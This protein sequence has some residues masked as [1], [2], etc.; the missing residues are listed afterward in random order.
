MS[1]ATQQIGQDFVARLWESFSSFGGLIIKHSS[2]RMLRLFGT[3]AV[4]FALN[5]LYRMHIKIKRLEQQ[6]RVAESRALESARHEAEAITLAARERR[7][8]ALVRWRVQ[9]LKEAVAPR[10]DLKVAELELE[11][12]ELSEGL[13]ICTPLESVLAILLDELQLSVMQEPKPSSTLHRESS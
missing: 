1:N 7:A 12:A 5:F 2:P 11:V 3:I 8:L 6:L 13:T 9:G 10:W 4:A